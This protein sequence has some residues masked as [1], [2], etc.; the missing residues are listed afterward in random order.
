M[1]VDITC[2]FK[3]VAFWR[4]CVQVRVVAATMALSASSRCATTVTSK[5]LG[6]SEGGV[7]ST[8]GKG[9][10]L[11]LPLHVKPKFQSSALQRTKSRRAMKKVGAT[12]AQDAVGSAESV[13]SQVGDEI[14]TTS[15]EILDAVDAVIEEGSA[16][17]GMRVRK[18]AGKANSRT[19]R[20]RA[21]VMCLA[22][23]MVRPCASNVA[24]NLQ[25]GNDLRRTASAMPA[26]RRTES[27]VAPTTL[28][29]QVS[30]A[31]TLKQTNLLGEQEDL[32]KL[33]TLQ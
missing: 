29:S 33:T 20:R 19:S 25:A 4:C 5:L 9:G 2:K 26:L 16:A 15:G 13:I 8:E 1:E 11:P 32:Q 18:S 31:T 28:V 10:V 24:G 21:L 3:L 14:S 23:G 30:L 17:A 7:A 6:A 27:A 12:T 22:L